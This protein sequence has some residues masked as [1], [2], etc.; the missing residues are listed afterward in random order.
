MFAR[1]IFRLIFLSL[2][3]PLLAF[4]LSAPATAQ[5]K[6]KPSAKVLRQGQKI[7]KENCQVCHQAD[8]IG[9]PGVAPSLTNPEFLAIS[10]D[11]FLERTIRDGR[12]DTSMMPFAHLGRSKVRAVVAF[13]RSHEKLRYRAKEVD[14]QPDARGDARFGKTWYMN[15][16]STCH[17]SD[18][19]GYESE[20]A[21]TAIGLPGFL[22]KV[23]DGY[24]RETV[25]VGRSNTRMLPFKGPT[26][27]A[28]LTDREIDDI[29][30]Y[31]RQA[32]KK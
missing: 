7:F 4:V 12:A 31:L 19:N 13:L 8:A 3:V 17:G 26:A 1:D 15:I 23:S 22:D 32:A 9:K 10:S 29:I 14:A 27:L 5:S 21:G 16:C 28:A 18:G 25:K 30:V 11:K 2:M 20:G 24:I 6:P